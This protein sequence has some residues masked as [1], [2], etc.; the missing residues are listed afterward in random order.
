MRAASA[1]LLLIAGCTCKG[2]PEQTKSVDPATLEPSNGSAMAGSGSGGGGGGSA[3]GSGWFSH[4]GPRDVHEFEDDPDAV[5][6]QRG[7][8]VALIVTSDEVEITPARTLR[9]ETRTCRDKFNACPN[10]PYAWQE[11]VGHC[12][13]IAVANDMV[14]TARHCLTLTAQGKIPRDT[15]YAIFGYRLARG[16]LPTNQVAAGEWHQLTAVVAKS[17]TLSDWI[18]VR[19]AP[20]IQS[21]HLGALVVDSE[22][23]S[24]NVYALGHP[25]GLPLKVAGGVVRRVQKGSIWTNLDSYPGNSGGPVFLKSSHRFV[26]M[27]SAGLP[28]LVPRGPCNDDVEGPED[29]GP[30]T[31]VLPVAHFLA[32]LTE[33]AKWP[34]VVEQGAIQ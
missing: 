23:V 26:G 2:E 8:H 20:A 31:R 28:G 21:S 7:R 19:V 29:A 18:L 4:Y 24:S 12:S 34:P 9:L 1:A 11:T 30:G 13:A 27:V 25:L 10:V 22:P 32:A 15:Y 3:A 6:G 5:V 33:H 17:N 14:L 16:E